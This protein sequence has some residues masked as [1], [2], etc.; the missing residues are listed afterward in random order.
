MRIPQS[1]RAGD[2]TRWRDVPFRGNL[3]EQITAASHSLAYYV[4][5]QAGQGVVIQGTANA[6]EWDFAHVFTLEAGKYFWTAVATEIG[7]SEQTT[8][9]AGQL[10]IL[11]SLAFTGTPSAFDGR[12]QARKD[13]EQVEAAI[14]SLMAGGAVAEYTIGGRR[15][16]RFD[17]ADLLMLRDKLKAEVVREE[18]AEMLA[19][20]L[21]DP[22]KIHIR[23]RR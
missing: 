4:R 5:G 3:G 21:G 16:K 11:P 17:L 19:N 2:T 15:L 23:F 8:A 13:L 7:G 9:G 10:E 22:H 6:Q 1:A 12:S 14:R 18:R 20:G